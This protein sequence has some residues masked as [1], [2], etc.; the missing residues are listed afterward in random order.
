VSWGGA[1]KLAA[2]P[3]EKCLEREAGL[4][5]ELLEQ[6]PGLANRLGRRLGGR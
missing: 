6:P 1:R 3:N 2:E 4:E 5:L